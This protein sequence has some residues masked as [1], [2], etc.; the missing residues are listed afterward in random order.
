MLLFVRGNSHTRG[1]IWKFSVEGLQSCGPCGPCGAAGHP[2]PEPWWTAP[3]MDQARDAPCS[4]VAH[5]HAGVVIL[6]IVPLS[7][8]TMGLTALSYNTFAIAG[9]AVSP[10]V[11]FSYHAS[12]RW[13]CSKP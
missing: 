2:W 12:R 3:A 11:S 4:V 7:Y 1:N 6:V 9:C 8:N 5:T 13:R 10:I